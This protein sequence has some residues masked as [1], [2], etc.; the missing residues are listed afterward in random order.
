MRATDARALFCQRE[1]FVPCATAGVSRDW[2]RRGPPMDGLARRSVAQSQLEPVCAIL[3]GCGGMP[4][5]LSGQPGF[6]I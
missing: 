5:Y 3:Q 1:A 2:P 4:T 6:L